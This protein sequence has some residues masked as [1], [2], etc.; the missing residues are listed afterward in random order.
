MT[1]LESTGSFYMQR[2]DTVYIKKYISTNIMKKICQSHIQQ[3]NAVNDKLCTDDSKTEQGVAFTV[4]SENFKRS[5]IVSNSTSI[6]TAEL[7][8]FLET[9]NYSTNVAKENIRTATDSRS[10]INTIRK[11]YPRSKPIV[12]K[13]QKTV[14]IRNKIFTHVCF[15]AISES[16]ETRVH[17]NWQYKRHLRH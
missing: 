13:I 12:Q 10:S 8:G 15:H 2:A 11:L 6:F 17:I 16:M 7:Y 9:I 4:Y 14:R 3:H 5:K 1:H